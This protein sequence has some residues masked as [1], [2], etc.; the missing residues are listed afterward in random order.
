MMPLRPD[1]AYLF[2]FNINETFVLTVRI[3]F[4][5]YLPVSQTQHFSV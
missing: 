4:P 3:E 5:Y 2:V 1:F